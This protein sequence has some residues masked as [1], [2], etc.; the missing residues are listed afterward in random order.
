MK[1]TAALSAGDE[2]KFWD[3]NVMNLKTPIGLL[4]VIF[5]CNRK[6]FCLLGGAEQ[7]N[8][9]LSRFQR[10]ATIVEGQE[11]SCYIYMEFG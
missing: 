5:F 2:K 8:L 9:K 1:T 6:N 11:A 10:E 7:C 4:R 3:T